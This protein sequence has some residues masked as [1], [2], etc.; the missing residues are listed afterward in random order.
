MPDTVSATNTATLCQHLKILLHS[1]A[2]ELRTLILSNSLANEELTARIAEIHDAALASV[3]HILSLH[4]GTPPKNFSWQYTSSDRTFHS[5]ENLTPQSF[6]EICVGDMELSRFVT[7][8]HDPRRPYMTTYAVPKA[9]ALMAGVPPPTFFNVPLNFIKHCALRCL[10]E[11]KMAVWFASP[12]GTVANRR[13]GILD[14]ATFESHTVYS[15]PLDPKTKEQRL[16]YQELVASHAMAITGVDLDQAEE[17]PS[18]SGGA[19]SSSQPRI[20]EEHCA[21]VRRWRVENSHGASSGNKGFYVMTNDFFEEDVLEVVVP[22][23]LLSEEARDKYLQSSPIPI[24]P[25]DPVAA[26]EFACECASDHAHT[27]T[28]SHDAEQEHSPS[29]RRSML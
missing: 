15:L 13:Q 27:A 11:E 26:P 17:E 24:P 7:L 14:P 6:K 29:W 9:A 8:I 25:W 4:L 3:F 12:F 18:G 10:L 28:S 21:R 5:Y 1:K 16:D 23:S 22:L 19:S 20:T 2:L